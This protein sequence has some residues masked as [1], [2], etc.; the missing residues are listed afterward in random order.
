MVLTNSNVNIIEWFETEV[1][2]KS[3]LVQ[4]L[5][6]GQGYLSV[7]EFTPSAVQCDTSWDEAWTI[8]M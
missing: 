5:Y 8:S 2:F 4:P 3:H 6:Y 1:T 7:E